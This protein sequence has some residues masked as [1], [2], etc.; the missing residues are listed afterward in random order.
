MGLIPFSEGPEPHHRILKVRDYD[1]IHPSL[2]KIRILQDFPGIDA[3][4]WLNL[5][6]D[7]EFIRF[8][9]PS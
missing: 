4:G 3:L 7:D 6:D 8:Q 9:L 2:Q 5:R 1:E